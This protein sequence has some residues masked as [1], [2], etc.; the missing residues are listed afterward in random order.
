M[1]FSRFGVGGIVV[2][3]GA[4]FV[5]QQMGL[6]PMHFIQGGGT[7]PTQ[8]AQGVDDEYR[9]M[10]EAVVGSTEDIWADIFQ[11]QRLNGGQYPQPIL[12]LFSRQVQS[13]CG[14]APSAVGPFYCPADNQ[15]YID[16]TFFLE[17]QRKFQVPGDFP[18]AYV[19]AHE[20]GHHVQTVLGY[21]AQIR[22]AQSRVSKAESNA[23]QVRMELQ[24]D[25]FAGLWASR[26]RQGIEPG[27]IDEALRAAAAIG[28]DALAVQ[29]GAKVNP[30]N[31]THGT[32][33]QRKRWFT[34]GYQAGDFRQ[35]DTFS[36]AQI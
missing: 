29:S 3:V 23:L 16:P 11:E 12:V 13:G 33:A 21:P 19:I 14:T 35:C 18:P 27:D 25:C 5:A 28:D 6:N 26:W 24:A 2:L 22:Q 9:D 1:I 36:A 32:S 30:E 20:V 4:F 7:A 10:V 15:V 8:Q 34:I 31:F 17:L